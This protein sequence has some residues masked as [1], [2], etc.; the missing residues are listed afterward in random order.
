MTSSLTLQDDETMAEK[1]RLAYDVF[2][3][4]V[5]PWT[6]P[7]AR[8]I[9]GKDV[10]VKPTA[11][12]PHTDGKTIFL[13]VDPRLADR[14][15]HEKSVC[16]VL[17]HEGRPVCKA[18]HIFESVL[19][20]CMHEISHITEQSFVDVDDAEFVEMMDRVL[21]EVP[22]PHGEK[23]RKR[24]TE[25]RDSGRMFSGLWETVA[26]VSPYLKTLLNALEDA[27]INS[28]M[29]K[30]RPG[31]H[32]MFHVFHMDTFNAGD[33]NHG[34]AQAHPDMQ[35]LIA[36]YMKASGYE[37]R[38]GWFSPEVIEALND[39]ALTR[40]LEQIVELR[41]VRQVYRRC[42]PILERIRELGY[43]KIHD[44][45][46]DDDEPDEGG[47]E[48]GDSK[49][50]A[51]SSEGE[52]MSGD[53]SS[54]RMELSDDD[55]P[56]KERAEQPQKDGDDDEHDD[57]DQEG[58]DDDDDT[59][60]D[61]TSG[62]S[63]DDD[64]DTEQEPP[65]PTPDEIDK[66]FKEFSGHDE[67]PEPESR[68]EQ[69]AKFEYEQAVEHL[70]RQGDVFDTPSSE[71]TGL[72]VHKFNG[73]KLTAEGRQIWTYKT[74]TFTEV[75][76][77]II[78]PALLRARIVFS[79]NRKSKMEPN[80]KSGAIAA[81]KLG[82][83][84]P[85]ADPRLF[86]KRRQ[87][88][89]KDYF[90]VIGLDM[91]G[92]TIGNVAETIKKAAFAQAELLDRL[93]IK[94]AMYAHTGLPDYGVHVRRGYTIGVDIAELKAA[95][96]PWKD[97]KVRVGRLGGSQANLDGHTI[98]FYRKRM[99]ESNATERILLYYTDGEMP[100]ENYTEEKAVLLRELDLMKRMNM[101][102]MGVGVD[103]DSPRQYGL[104]TVEIHSVR[105]L[106]KVVDALEVKLT[107]G[108]I[109]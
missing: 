107:G 31:T 57:D 85:V 54:G 11:G 50:D 63:G 8:V 10:D 30:A 24:M 39:R 105:D 92:S 32:R 3:N 66:A 29:Y 103:T 41:S 74:P 102:F 49:P 21:I 17:D 45:D 99:A 18:C 38:E 36:A 46:D 75:D 34:W 52:S 69:R 28:A 37:L 5:V 82:L 1:A 13:T 94:F 97:C 15:P 60:A 43:C 12:G 77:S 67:Q 27:R 16:G 47:R 88:G 95:H 62:G 23:M 20:T 56:A 22:G 101:K 53:A 96:E 87:P 51:D 33:E 86:E 81:S 58:D 7:V 65:A 2:M 83:R 59:D 6:R 90:V 64:D 61:S 9:T 48:K 91:S 25:L 79:D 35:V 42:F 26:F 89:R 55:K 104:E 80:L 78:S 100:A 108:T 93:G 19:I 72:K 71:L 109:R 44:P 40:Q 4:Q 76:Q 73:G 106:R 68:E 70:T 84:A 14:T 98:E